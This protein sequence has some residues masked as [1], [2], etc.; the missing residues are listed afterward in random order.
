L[1]V[2]DTNVLLYLRIE[3]PH[4]GAAEQLFRSDPEWAAPLLWRS[5]FRNVLVGYVRRGTLRMDECLRLVADAEQQLAG[6]EFE[7][8][9]NEVIQLAVGSKC[10]G[11]DCEFVALAMQLNVPLATLDARI[12]S[13]FPKVTVRP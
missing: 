8:A 2:V 10:T 7:V 3:G 9:S 13:A 5:E 12:L 1:I 6:Y 11:Y 4:T